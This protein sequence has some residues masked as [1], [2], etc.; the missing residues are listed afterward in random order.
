MIGQILTSRPDTCNIG[1]RCPLLADNDNTRL[2]IP[3]V[4]ND[5]P[6]YISADVFCIGAPLTALAAVTRTHTQSIANSTTAAVGDGSTASALVHGDPSNVEEDS[7]P[8][9]DIVDS[10]FRD[11]TVAAVSWP[12]LRHVIDP[13]HKHVCGHADHGDMLLLLQQNHILNKR[14][15]IYPRR[16]IDHCCVCLAA[17]KPLHSCEVSFRSFSRAFNDVVCIDCLYLED[18][19]ILH[20]M[21]TATRYS[22][23]ALADELSTTERIVLFESTW[24]ASFW[25]PSTLYDN[26][27]FNHPE[28]A[29]FLT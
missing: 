27:A 21:N 10:T 12:Q 2:F 15:D 28:I 11:I 26:Q 16:L 13:V 22:V 4:Y 23:G 17:V 3:M 20:V 5:M 14:A 24:L 19:R 8:T 7:P 18:T 25:A 9:V 29:D 6:Q 1:T